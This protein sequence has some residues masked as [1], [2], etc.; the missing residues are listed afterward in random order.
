MSQLDMLSLEIVV[1]AEIEV[2]A[3]IE[4]AVVAGAEAAAAEIAVEV[5]IVVGD[6]LESQMMQVYDNKLRTFQVPG[7]CMAQVVLSAFSAEL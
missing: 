1:D 7:S 2:A 6:F 4:A 3:E 5:G